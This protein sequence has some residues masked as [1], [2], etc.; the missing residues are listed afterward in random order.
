MAKNEKIVLVDDSEVVDASNYVPTASDSVTTTKPLAET[1]ENKEL[2]ENLQALLN[3]FGAENDIE[4][5]VGKMSRSNNMIVG[6]QKNIEGCPEGITSAQYQ[7]YLDTR[8]M[9]VVDGKEVEMTLADLG[10]NLNDEITAYKAFKPK[11]RTKVLT[12]ARLVGGKPNGKTNKLTVEIDGIDKL[13]SMT[14]EDWLDR[15]ENPYTPE[16]LSVKNGINVWGHRVVRDGEGN[17]VLDDDG[18]EVLERVLRANPNR[19]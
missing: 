2:Q 12:T 5:T 3:T 6:V 1:P 4:F 9:Q 14:V 17:P 18:E 8:V 10:I 11:S 16:D 19:K 13:D 15:V 7:S